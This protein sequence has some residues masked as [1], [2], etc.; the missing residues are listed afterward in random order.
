VIFA[1]QRV[2]HGRRAFDPLSGARHLRGAY[3]A[4]D[5]FKDF[6]KDKL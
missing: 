3:V 4:M 6:V 5:D 1:N 2:L